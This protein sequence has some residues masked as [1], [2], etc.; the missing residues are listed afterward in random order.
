QRQIEVHLRGREHVADDSLFRAG[1]QLRNRALEHLQVHLETHRGDRAVLL[2]P[3]EV[4]RAADLEVAERDLESLTELMQP[5]DDV[6]ALIRL[7]GQRSPRVVQ[8]VG[9]RAP[10]RPPDPSAQLAE[11]SEAE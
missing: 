11:L 6:E 3:K 2:S 7:L 1:A 10:A 9:I 5:G 8:K 4:A